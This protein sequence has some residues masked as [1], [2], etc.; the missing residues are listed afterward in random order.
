MGRNCGSCYSS[1]SRPTG[2]G[3]AG[4]LMAMSWGKAPTASQG[5][6]IV[7]TVA[8]Q[9]SVPFASPH[10]LKD[11]CRR[12][13]YSPN[14]FAMPCC[15][16]DSRRARLRHARSHPSNGAAVRQD[17]VRAGHG[18]LAFRATTIMGER[19]RPPKW[20]LTLGSVHPPGSVPFRATNGPHQLETATRLLNS[21]LIPG[22]DALAG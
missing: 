14:C 19:D 11:F 10:T 16:K 13:E 5:E 22:Y 8:E 7:K 3:T 4:F 15:C 20:L 6:A 12:V 18:F 17:P 21:P 1:L 9:E 2:C